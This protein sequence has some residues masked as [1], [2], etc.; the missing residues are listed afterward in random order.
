M[1]GE[2]RPGARGALIA[3]GVL[4]VVAGILWPILS[5]YAGRLPG[6]IVWKRGNWTCIFPIAT[7]IVLSILLSLILWLFRR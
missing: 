4:L 7:S 2:F 6:D 1:Q 5:R 3:I